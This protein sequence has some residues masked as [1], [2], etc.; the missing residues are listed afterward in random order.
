M[1]D[2]TEKATRAYK[3][4]RTMKIRTGRLLKLAKHLESGKLLHKSFNF[5]EVNSG[6]LKANHC[7]TVGCAM[8]EMPA[9]FPKQIEFNKDGE[10]RKVNG[11]DEDPVNEFF[12]ID[13]RMGGH[14]FVPISQKCISYGGVELSGIATKHQVASNI[15]EF[16]KL[17]KAGKVK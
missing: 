4:G 7:G 17:V 3:V 6:K 5:W 2:V 14:L 9:V 16:V 1:W 12:G 11:P 10:V 13:N 15:R 8:G